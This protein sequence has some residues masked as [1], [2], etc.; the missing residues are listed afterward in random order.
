MRNNRVRFNDL[1][2]EL[3]GFY[4]DFEIVDGVIYF[5]DGERRTNEGQ[6]KIIPTECCNFRI[7]AYIAKMRE[8]V[9]SQ[10]LDPDVLSDPEEQA[11]VH[12]LLSEVDI[13][14]NGQSSS[15]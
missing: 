7:R 2:T 12:E 14:L 9:F 11:K 5:V 13:L 10:I 3:A 4:D 8:T 15:D 1:L 6:I